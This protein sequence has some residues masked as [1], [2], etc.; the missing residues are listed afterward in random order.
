M[1]VSVDHKE[2]GFL[3]KIAYDWKLFETPLCGLGATSGLPYLVSK[4]RQKVLLGG[5]Q[6]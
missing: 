2:R 3:E 1:A 4:A 6:P 5:Y